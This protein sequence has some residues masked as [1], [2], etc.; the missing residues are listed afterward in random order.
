ML[1]VA[2]I[3]FL[4]FLVLNNNK[5]VYS[6]FLK[7]PKADIQTYASGNRHTHS[8]FYFRFLVLICL[9]NPSVTFR[10]VTI[11]TKDIQKDICHDNNYGRTGICS[12]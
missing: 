3:N 11:K 9:L 6:F 1:N 2:E 8:S 4:F 12:G 5:L 7:G 10:I